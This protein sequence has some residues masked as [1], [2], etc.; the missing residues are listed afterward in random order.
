MRDETV[1]AIKSLK[2]N[3]SSG[4]DSGITPEALLDGGEAMAA[5]VHNFC[6]KVYT[7]KVPPKQSPI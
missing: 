3:K 6:Y 4:L 5:I 1:N 2:R 7:N